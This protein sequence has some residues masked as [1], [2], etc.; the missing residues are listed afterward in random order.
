VAASPKLIEAILEVEASLAAE[1]EGWSLAALTA[2][3]QGAPEE[4]E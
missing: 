4:E 2:L 3:R 1:A